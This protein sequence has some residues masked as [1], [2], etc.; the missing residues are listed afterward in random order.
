VMT[1]DEYARTRGVEK[2][3]VQLKNAKAKDVATVLQPFVQREQGQAKGAVG[4]VMAGE[5]SNKL[6]LLVPAPLMESLL[7]IVES[8]DVPFTK[9]AVRVIALKHLE[10]ALLAPKLERF[11]AEPVGRQGR[12]SRDGLS[13][14]ANAPG[15]PTADRTEPSR[16]G[17]RWVVQFMVEAKLNAIVLRGVPADVAQTEELIAK[18]DIAPAVEVIAYP[19]KYT[20]A[21]EVFQTLQ[22]IANEEARLTGRDQEQ[23]PTRLRLAVSEQNNQVI[24]EGSSRDHARIAGIIA[25]IDKPLPPSSGGI[26]VYRLENSTAKEAAAVIQEVIDR[27]GQKGP[28]AVQEKNL[29]GPKDFQPVGAAGSAQATGTNGSGSAAAPPRPGGDSPSGGGVGGSG[30][31]NS[32]ADVIP[33]QVTAAPEINAVVIRASAA[34]H[35][36]FAALIRELDKPRDQVMLEVTLV[37]VRNVN[38]FNIGVELSGAHLGGPEPQTIGFSTFGVGQ[39]DSAGGNLSL[40]KAPPFGLNFGVFQADE[41]SFVFNALKTV[42]DTRITATPKILVEDN[43]PAEIKQLSKEPYSIVSQ[44]QTTTLT[45]FGGFAEAGATLTVIPHVSR[46]DWLRL[47][48]QVNLSS[49]DKRTPQQLAAN[50]PPPVRQNASQGTVRIPAGYTVALGGLASTRDEQVK[51]G[52]PLLSDIPLL[53]TLF[54][55]SA[56]GQVKETLFIFIRPVLLRDLAFRDLRFLSEEDIRQA[57]IARHEY[58]ENPLK[59]LSPATP[60]QT[61]GN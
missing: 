14:S 5:E 53:G 22:E 26:R 3:I 50:L 38:N 47:E 10:A 55:N 41:F 42:G 4:R 31:S 7:R 1:F 33:A 48:Y 11:L 20:T 35:E 61:R 16:A 9:D 54:S 49:F 36:E 60:E 45:S 6:I 21:R 15:T 44:G 2:R 13:L 43:A 51:D 46:E 52:I 57:Q 18:L 32:A 12:T 8:L 19:L 17:E 28:M 59:T 56:S 40:A 24:A 34:E 23:D 58:P 30:E 25:A 39:V 29:G 27:K 37:T